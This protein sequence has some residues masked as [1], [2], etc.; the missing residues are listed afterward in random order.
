MGHGKIE[1]MSLQIIDKI[2]TY[3][4]FMSFLEIFFFFCPWSL[5]FFGDKGSY[6]LDK[7]RTLNNA[8]FWE[9]FECCISD[10]DSAFYGK[11]VLT[12]QL[13]DIHMWRF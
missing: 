7:E 6:I 11:S 9:D 10:F 3:S 12:F 4:L 2:M 8:S 13:Q 5:K 1:L